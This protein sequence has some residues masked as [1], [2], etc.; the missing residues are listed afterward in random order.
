MNKKQRKISYAIG[1]TFGILS[2]GSIAAGILVKD[3][4]GHAAANRLG[5]LSVAF[6]GMA[7]LY[8][9]IKLPKIMASE[10]EEK[11]SDMI[12]KRDFFQRSG[13]WR[14]RIHWQR[15]LRKLA[16]ISETIICIRNAFLF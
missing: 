8:M 7:L 16:L 10:M 4:L 6:I 5:W 14:M 3:T 15:S 1:S 12:T 11:A 9:A 2:L 13:F